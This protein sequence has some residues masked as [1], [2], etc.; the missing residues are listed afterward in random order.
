MDEVMK[1]EKAAEEEKHHPSLLKDMVGR[2]E[3]LADLW[4]GLQNVIGERKPRM[5][6]LIGNPGIGKTRILTEFLGKAREDVE[7]LKILRGIC[8]PEGRAYHVFT[9]ILRSR[10]G[11]FEGLAPE[12]VQEQFRRELTDVLGDR[13]VTEFLHFLGSYVDVRFPDNPFLRTME[14][15]PEQFDEIRKSVLKRFFE[16]D[17]EKRPLLLTFEDLQYV[18]EE[19]LELIRY[20]GENLENCPVL[21]V[22]VTTSEIFLKKP[23]WFDGPKNHR[24]V[25]IGP[26]SR[27][28]AERMLMHLLSQFEDL[29][30]ELVSV[31]TNLSGGNPMF[32]EQIVQILKDNKTIEL[33]DKGKWEL[34]LDRLKNLR[35]PLSVEE[36]VQV[37]IGALTTYERSMLEKALCMGGVF[38]LGGLVMLDRIER[39]VPEI[40]GGSDEQAHIIREYLEGLEA[41]DYI[42]RI[43]DSTF[44]DDEEYAFK[45]N[46]EREMIRRMSNP[47]M[48][49]KYH[50]YLSEWLEFKLDEK[51]EEQLD[52]LATHLRDG[53]NAQKAGLY[54]FSAG[55]LARNRYAHKKAV[56][57]YEQALGCLGELD[58]ALRIEMYHNLGDVYQASGNFEKALENFQKMKILGW[59]LNNLSKSGAAHNRIG[60][61]HR[62]AGRLDEALRYLGTGLALFQQSQD[63]RGV[64]SSLDDIGKVHW[65]KGGYALALNQMMEA[66]EIRQR[67]GDLRSIAL[68]YN[69]IG[70]VKQDS[71]NYEEA[72]SYF[73]ESLRLRREVGDISGV[74][75]SL[76]NLGTV[77]EDKGEHEKAINVWSE[78][79]DEAKRIEDRL[80]QTYLLTNI[81]VAQYQMAR[82]ED[83]VKTLE[84]A[85]Q[86]A[87]D[88][89]DRLLIGETE[90]AMGK[91]YMLMGEHHK[92][93]EHLKIA[94]ETFERLRSKVQVAIALRTLAE[95]TS[96][97][98]WGEQDDRKAEDIFK[99]SMMILEEV[100][101]ELELARTLRSFAR[102]LVKQG[103]VQEGEK[104][105]LRA[106]AIFA[107]LKVSTERLAHHE[108]ARLSHFEVD[109]GYPPTPPVAEPEQDGKE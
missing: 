94:V 14:A 39:E 31:V 56:G 53:G 62:E 101:N 84:H 28:N 8:R 10:F 69:N 7:G 17:S 88:L 77:Y 5:V 26:L 38:W 108:T 1:D 93:R 70:L 60:R 67:I 96:E 25:D 104:M 83:A 43:P 45:H 19:T 99:R 73:T 58:A 81:G 100:G 15:N 18:N 9:R 50:A 74:I 48:L 24:R 47:A 90:R 76:N 11:I 6:T 80:R 4:D 46:L 32:L 22:N 36:A 102:M 23:D 106:K 107:K 29:P 2:T 98:G 105:A 42:M 54:F 13:R 103:R 66:L 35:L 91:T 82:Y 30:D 52:L 33:N 37:R 63:D 34:H 49:K 44:P 79:L 68:S 51:G 97:G 40:W 57:L 20:L 21:I 71:G 95:E 3:E 92:A 16:V 59:R 109:T 61:V 89:G 87:R 72:L 85:N 55:N 12:K 86:F 41:R 78:G 64:A 27:I 65:L 75:V